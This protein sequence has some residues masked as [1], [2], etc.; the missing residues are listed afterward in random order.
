MGH[1][2]SNKAGQNTEQ[3]ALS[4]HAMRHNNARDGMHTQACGGTTEYAAGHLTIL[5][6]TP[7]DMLMSYP[8]HDDQKPSPYVCSCRGLRGTAA[9]ATTAKN[10]SYKLTVLQHSRFHTVVHVWPGCAQYSLTA[11]IG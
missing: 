4:R 6:V 10:K 1:E 11:M 7:N 2:L 3:R 9:L 5:L 8:Q